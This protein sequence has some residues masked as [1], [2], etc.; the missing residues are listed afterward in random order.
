MGLLTNCT[1]SVQC[2][3]ENHAQRGKRFG[4]FDDPICTYVCVV[5]TGPEGVGYIYV[6]G[7]MLT[8]CA[9]LE[10]HSSHSIEDWEQ[11]DG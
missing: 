2:G 6:R 5:G 3:G 9:W 7:H 8:C 11:L 10:Y 4:V 1:M